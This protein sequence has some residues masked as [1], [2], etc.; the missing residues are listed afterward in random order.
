MQVNGR[1]VTNDNDRYQR[2]EDTCRD[3]LEEA[4]HCHVILSHRAPTAINERNAGLSLA[5][6]VLSTGTTNYKFI[7]KKRDSSHRSVAIRTLQPVQFC[8]R[9]VKKERAP[10]KYPRHQSIGNAFEQLSDGN[11]KDCNGNKPEQ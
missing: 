4:R 10:E 6:N 11:Y 5:F 9:N 3:Q 2:T 8:N 7:R 1:D